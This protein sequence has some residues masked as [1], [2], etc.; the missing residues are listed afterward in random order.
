[1]LDYVFPDYLWTK[2]NVFSIPILLKCHQNHYS[3]DN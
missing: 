1:M 2:K 3:L